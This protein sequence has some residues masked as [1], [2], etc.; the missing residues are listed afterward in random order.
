MAS[1]LPSDQTDSGADDESAETVMI[2]PEYFEGHDCKVGDT[3]KVT[4]KDEDGTLTLAYQE[5][6]EQDEGPMAAMDRHFAEKGGA[7]TQPTY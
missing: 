4:A 6:P 3:F 5:G 2:P 1:D 7:G